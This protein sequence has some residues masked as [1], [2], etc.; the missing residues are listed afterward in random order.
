MRRLAPPVTYNESLFGSNS[1][2]LCSFAFKSPCRDSCDFSYFYSQ[3]VASNEVG[4]WGGEGSSNRATSGMGHSSVVKALDTVF[5]VREVELGY[6][7]IHYYI[8]VAQLG[9]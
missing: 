7:N 8:P 9:A 5:I 6:E 4:I 3:A 2:M 1:I